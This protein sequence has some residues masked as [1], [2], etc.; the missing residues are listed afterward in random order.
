[1]QDFDLKYVERYP[2]ITCEYKEPELCPAA[3]GAAAVIGNI[4]VLFGLVALVLLL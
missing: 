3:A 1:M 2:N 4:A